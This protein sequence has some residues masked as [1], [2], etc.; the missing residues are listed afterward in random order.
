[1]FQRDREANKER[2]RMGREDVFVS[3]LMNS[4]G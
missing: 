4:G 3:S 1:M 2:E